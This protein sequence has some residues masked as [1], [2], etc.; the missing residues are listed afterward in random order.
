M[1][2]QEP[3][4]KN[5]RNKAG[6]YGRKISE[7]GASPP[8]PTCHLPLRTA[9]SWSRLRASLAQSNRALAGLVG[10]MPR[11]TSRPR[12]KR[13]VSKGVVAEAHHHLTAPCK[14][15]LRGPH[16]LQTDMPQGPMIHD[17]TFTSCTG[18]ASAKP[19]S[20]GSKPHF[21]RTGSCTSPSNGRHSSERS[22]DN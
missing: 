19:S 16:R 12:P 4:H 15:P 1:V 6:E 5:F 22:S 21:E 2:K 14:R 11:P 9:S 7:T 13:L 17:S 18:E 20:D 8:F 3:L 10:F